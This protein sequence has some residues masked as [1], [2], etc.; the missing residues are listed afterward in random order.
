MKS[1]T[2]KKDQV[3]FRQDDAT[4]CMYEVEQGKVG[5]FAE[6]RTPQEE[7]LTGISSGGIFGEMGLLEGNLRSATAVA[8]EDGTVCSVITD[9]EMN[10]FFRTRPEKVLGLLRTLSQRIRE[11]DEKYMNVCRLIYENDQAEKKGVRP[12]EEV[13][14]Q[15]NE[16]LREFGN[17]NTLWLN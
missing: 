10:E 9:A 17:I 4:D 16:I 3:I 2:L 11:I 13:N 8:L 15:L 6:Y 12:S 1:I 7:L 5:I 14:R